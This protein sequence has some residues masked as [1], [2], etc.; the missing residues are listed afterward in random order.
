MVRQPYGRDTMTIEQV[1]RVRRD[2]NIPNSLRF[3]YDLKL[4]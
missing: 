4:A 1:D 3:V 2:D